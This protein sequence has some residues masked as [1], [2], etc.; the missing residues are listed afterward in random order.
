MYFLVISTPK[1][2]PPSAARGNQKQWWD[3]L[4][5]LVKSGTAKHVYTK[6]GRGAV[7]I[8]DVDSHETLHKL[9]NQWSETIPATFEVEALLPGDHQKRIA[10]A[11][12]NPMGL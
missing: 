1:A 12:T 5:P 8:F 3:W 10:M 7:I 6:L 2:E 4:D 11:G 9:V